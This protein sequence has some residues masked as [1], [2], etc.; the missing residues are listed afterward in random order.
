MT[1]KS[2]HAAQAAEPAP[3]V[4]AVDPDA[5]DLKKVKTTK[6]SDAAQAFVRNF[7]A[8]HGV[9]QDAFTDADAVALTEAI[10]AAV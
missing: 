5:L 3:I 4:P 10:D 7:L 1:Q 2:T 8:G 9:A 6:R